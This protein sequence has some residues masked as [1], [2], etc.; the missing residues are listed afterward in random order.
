MPFPQSYYKELLSGFIRNTVSIEQVEELY[1]FIDEEPALYGSLMNEPDLM[2]LVRETA[3]DTNDQ[4]QPAADERVWQYLQAYAG[5]TSLKMQA[6]AGKTAARWVTRRWA[7]AAAV[8]LVIVTTV[9]VFPTRRNSSTNNGSAVRSVQADVTAPQISRAT[10]TLANGRRV[11]LDSLAKGLVARQGSVRLV[12]LNDGQIAY[13]ADAGAAGQQ[14]AYNTLSNPRG[15]KV[16]NIDLSDGSHV[17]LN[18]GSS[19]TYPVGFSAIERKVQV[20]G[21]A[22]FEVAPDVKRPFTVT[23][24]LV[25]IVV[26][27]THFNVNAFYDDDDLKVTL[28]EGAVKVSTASSGILLAPGQQAAITNANTWNGSIRMVSH[29]DLEAVMAWKDGLFNFNQVPLQEVMRQLS[30]WYDMEVE[31]EGAVTTKALGGEMQRDLNLAD[32]LNGLRDIGV[33]Y[34]IEGKKLII[35]P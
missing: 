27:G 6:D 12:K 20:S 28:L 2:N 11:A 14:L 15:S 13:Q 25:T 10:I 26:L 31:Y 29:P 8:V 35:L 19:I 22:Y 30:R 4:L 33:H 23:K 17:W 5:R 16:V 18:A 32:V 7:A 24:A 9:L 21:E 34:K 3:E 1:R